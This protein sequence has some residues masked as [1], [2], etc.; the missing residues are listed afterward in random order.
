MVH[1][2]VL[3]L[4]TERMQLV[5]SSFWARPSM[6]AVFKR[7]DGLEKKNIERV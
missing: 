7:F 5:Q 4:V 2:A 1:V 3:T 6:L